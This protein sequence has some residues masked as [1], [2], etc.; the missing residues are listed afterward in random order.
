MEDEPESKVLVTGC[1]ND[2]F[3]LQIHSD[4]FQDMMFSTDNGKL[5]A[6]EDLDEKCVTPERN[7]RALPDDI[8]TDYIKYTC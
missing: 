4:M 2:S 8:Y 1:K 5:V 6:I 3:D 7:S